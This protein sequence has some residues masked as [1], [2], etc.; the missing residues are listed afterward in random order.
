MKKRILS[1]LLVFL[2][3][4]SV[5][6][7]SFAE[8]TDTITGKTA[9]SQIYKTGKTVC[10]NTYAGLYKVT[11]KNG[12]PKKVKRLVKYGVSSMIK[13]GSYIYYMSATSGAGGSVCRVNVTTGKKK[14]L[15]DFLDEGDYAIANNTLYYSKTVWPEYDED[16]DYDDEYY[17]DDY[18]DD[19]DE[20]YTE[21]YAANLDGSSPRLVDVTLKGPWKRSNVKSYRA[22]TKTKGKYI[23]AYLKNSKGKFY[24]GRTRVPVY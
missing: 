18:Y 15:T 19:E 13:Q 20:G 8:A 10:C 17:D 24:L 11:L 23:Y 5:M 9:Y 2:F 7:L 4:V 14:A 16:E 22:Y 1:I 12:R 21:T 6:P 3:A